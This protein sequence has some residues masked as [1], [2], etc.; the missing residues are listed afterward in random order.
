MRLIIF[1]V[2]IFILKKIVA[3]DVLNSSEGSKLNTSRSS[4]VRILLGQLGYKLLPRRTK[5][6]PQWHQS[7]LVQ[8][9]SQPF[10]NLFGGNSGCQ[11]YPTTA[12]AQTGQTQCA[13]GYRYDY[14]AQRCRQMQY[15][16]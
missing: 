16:K 10:C 1:V 11:Q 2:V 12:N 15:G 7:L 13:D 3:E 5:R 14:T 9:L 6:S 8:G 4:A